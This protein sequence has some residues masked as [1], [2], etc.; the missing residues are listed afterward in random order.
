[1]AGTVRWAGVGGGTGQTFAA[2]PAPA[3]QAG[4]PVLRPTG[5]VIFATLETPTP[6]FGN[7]ET[8]ARSRHQ[9]RTLGPLHNSRGRDGDG[10][11]ASGQT[12]R[13]G[14]GH[15]VMWLLGR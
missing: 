5:V 6:R 10:S 8:E 3:G 15:I 1:M 9:A 14:V 12:V 11:I 13:R 4:A 7:H 2:G